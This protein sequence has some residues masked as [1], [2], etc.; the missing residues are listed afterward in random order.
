MVWAIA[1]VVAAVMVRFAAGYERPLPTP[2]APPPGIARVGEALQLERDAPAWK[3]VAVEAAAPATSTWSDELPSRVRIDAARAAR[4]GA[5]VQGR[6]QRVLVEAGDRVQQG[7]ALFEVVA[8]AAAEL[9]ASVQ[10]A[11]IQV[12]AAARAAARASALA[13]EGAIPA[14]EASEASAALRIAKVELEA[15]RSR[16]RLLDLDGQGGWVARAPRDGVVVEK[17]VLV[18]QEVGPE[19]GPLIT[20]GDLGSVWVVAE[21]FESEV[22][23]IEVGAQATITSPALPGRTLRGTVEH[24]S[25]VVDPERHTVA[26]R[27][28]CDNSDGLLR[29][30][31]YARVRIA[32]RPLPGAVTVA[33]GALVSGGEAQWV[34]LERAPGRFERRRVEGAHIEA[35]RLVVLGGLLPGDRV[36]VRGALLL[37]NHLALT[38]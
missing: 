13:R 27:I 19:A 11:E 16:L 5:P 21:V 28:R 35:G 1:V 12:G 31:L 30:N 36:A 32:L 33:P 10:R 26:V 34:Y 7:A 17:N 9:R 2:D 3:M 24:V 15:A 38:R 14:K 25:A 23:G 22:A 18:G 4:V 20:L 29:A 37:D 6:V 8:P